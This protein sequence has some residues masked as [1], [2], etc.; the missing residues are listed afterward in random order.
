MVERIDWPAIGMDL[1]QSGYGIT[2]V[3][4]ALGKHKGTVQGWLQHGKEPRFMEGHRLL[5]LWATVVAGHRTGVT[6]SAV[7]KRN[8]FKSSPLAVSAVVS[9][10]LTGSDVSQNRATG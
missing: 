4:V 6:F 7:V 10:N 1:R 2:R 5:A 3:A 9:T 8:V